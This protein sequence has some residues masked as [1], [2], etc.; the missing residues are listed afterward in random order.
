MAKK[1]RR[2]RQEVV[3]ILC[4]LVVIICGFILVSPTVWDVNHNIQTTEI[5]QKMVSEENITDLLSNKN[6]NIGETTKIRPLLREK[7]PA[8]LFLSTYDLTL[9][10]LTVR[11]SITERSEAT[12][13]EYNRF[14]SDDNCQQI[15]MY[16]TGALFVLIRNLDIIEINVDNYDFP[17]CI[18]TREE[19]DSIFGTSLSGIYTAEDW[20]HYLIKG[21][22]YNDTCRKAFFTLHPLILDDK[23]TIPQN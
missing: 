3:L 20:Q 16:N 8:G 6:I 12:A 4:T 14:W 9:N 15:V 10:K 21:G 18:I 11:Y 17:T 1:R 13:E 19:A 22:V 2:L 5:H 23:S 7:L